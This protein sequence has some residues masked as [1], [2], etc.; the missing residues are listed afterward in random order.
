MNLSFNITLDSTDDPNRTLVSNVGRAI[1]KKL[2]VK[3]EGIEILSLDDFDVFPCY[4]DLWRTESEKRNAVRQGIIHSGSCTLTCMKL[5][6]NVK[7][8]GFL[9]VRDVAIANAYGNKFIIHVDF[10]MPDSAVPNY[11]AGLGNRLCYEIMFNDY[12]RFF[13]STGVK[14]DSSYKI[15]DIS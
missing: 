6:I 3:F 15:A 1:V 4:R 7:D 9:S 8:K 14:R 12:E 2:A 5:R 11:Q 10:K 13:Q